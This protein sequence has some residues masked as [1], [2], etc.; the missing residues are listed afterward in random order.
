MDTT[1][2]HIR[3]L[4]G[5][6]VGLL[7]LR[8]GVPIAM[9]QRRSVMGETTNSGNVVTGAG[10]CDNSGCDES[11]RDCHTT[12]RDNYDDS[13]EIATT[14]SLSVDDILSLEFPSGDGAEFSVPS[15]TDSISWA[16]S[17]S[18]VCSDSLVFPVEISSSVSIDWEP[19]V[20]IIKYMISVMQKREAKA[21]G[22]TREE[23]KKRK[24]AVVK[25]TQDDSV[26]FD[27]RYLY[28][29]K[30]VCN[31]G[32]KDCVL[33]GR[34]HMRSLVER[35]EKSKATAPDGWT[36]YNATKRRDGAVVVCTTGTAEKTVTLRKTS[37]I[38]QVVLPAYDKDAFE[39]SVYRNGENP[40]KIA[41]EV[42]MDAKEAIL[43]YHMKYYGVEIEMVGSL[44][45]RYVNDEWTINDRVLFE[46]NFSKYGTKFSK[47]MMNK[48]EDELKIYYRFYINNYLPVNW[49]ETERALF[50]QLIGMC[51]KDWTQM[52]E[53]FET[54]DVNE[55]MVYYNSYFKKLDDEGRLKEQQLTGTTLLKPELQQKRR[56]RKPRPAVAADEEANHS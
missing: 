50:A 13:S 7:K 22:K 9:K 11:D 18:S 1:T 49:S 6:R 31:L 15:D 19:I 14:V 21:P 39:Y 17:T 53:H 32:K 30:K 43:V 46:E 48:S 27:P 40:V 56:G 33:Y 8:V 3:L 25:N 10:N 36:S 5:P 23:K 44:L 42:G 55:L 29:L 24:P 35:A 2:L 51:K 38:K 41:H 28:F 4:V 52:A 47:Y 20:P 34:D 26:F 16:D 37:T 12:S 54:K 45:E